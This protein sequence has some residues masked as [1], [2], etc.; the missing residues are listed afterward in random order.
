MSP[1]NIH[2]EESTA[3]APKKKKSKTL[4][5]MLGIG[6][7]VLVPVIGSTFAAII[8]INTADE[9]QFAQ[10][11]A[12]TVGCDDTIFTAAS[13]IYDSGFKLS[14]ITLSD[15]NVDACKGKTFVVSIVD[16]GTD[17]VVLIDG[18]KQISFSIPA[19]ASNPASKTLENLLP[20]SG[21][22]A[23]LESNAG[24]ALADYAD[25]QNG[26]IE[27]EFNSPSLAS[28]DVV[29]ILLQTS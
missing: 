29:R 2:P 6:A 7:L 21:F 18:D 3:S 25:V 13:S 28:A 8:T 10:G 26:V 12:V 4:K 22:A 23:E 17:E 1:L 15:I 9:V 19:A 11:N 14:K 27:I 5:V 20:V 24:A 16:S